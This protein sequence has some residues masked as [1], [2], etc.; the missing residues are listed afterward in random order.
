MTKGK[1]MQDYTSITTELGQISREANAFRKIYDQALGNIE[2]FNGSVNGLKGLLVSA[3]EGL[4]NIEF[5]NYKLQIDFQYARVNGTPCGKL[6][7]YSFDEDN[8]RVLASTEEF[9]VNGNVKGTSLS[10]YD[11]VE[12]MT[13][14]LNMVKGAI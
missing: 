10:L 9:E 4:I 6:C 13:V 1:L 14:V 5:I 3:S 8:K 2:L 12:T 7:I 11:E